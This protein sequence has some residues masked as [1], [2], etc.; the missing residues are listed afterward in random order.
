MKKQINEKETGTA[1]VPSI[2]PELPSAPPRPPSGSVYRFVRRLS[3][4]QVIFAGAVLA[5][6]FIMFTF[7]LPDSIRSGRLDR[8]ATVATLLGPSCLVMLQGRCPPNAAF[9]LGRSSISWLSQ[10]R[11]LSRFRF[12]AFFLLRLVF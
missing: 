6:S 10:C 4:F 5:M 8:S 7:G 1:G 2:W 9:L 3:T 12:R 11:I